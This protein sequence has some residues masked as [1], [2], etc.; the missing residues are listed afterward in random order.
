MMPTSIEQF[1]AP[2]RYYYELAM[3]ELKY[4]LKIPTYLNTN[5]EIKSKNK[6]AYANNS[7][8]SYYHSSKIKNK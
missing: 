1:T 6:D 5:L 4:E 8:E 2:G 3:E 7:S